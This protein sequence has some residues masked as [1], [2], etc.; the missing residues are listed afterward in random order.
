MIWYVALGGALGSASRFLL[1]AFLQQR[2]GVAFPVGTLIV[3]I[4]GSFLLGFLLRYALET[5]AISPE[6][7]ALLT[8]GFCGGYTTFS[9]FSYETAALL[10]DGEASRA[11]LY[12]VLSVAVSLAGVFAGFGLAREILNARRGL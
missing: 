8:T 2:S 5:P 1:G 9:T 6:V 11:A 12:I 7:R 4:T 10:E 3:N